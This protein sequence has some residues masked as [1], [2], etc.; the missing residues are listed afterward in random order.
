MI[1]ESKIGVNELELFEGSKGLF[2]TVEIESG[3]KVDLK[4]FL[5]SDKNTIAINSHRNRY[6]V[7]YKSDL[8]NNLTLIYME[9][10][11]DYPMFNPFK[12]KNA[13]MVYNKSDN[14]IYTCTYSY[15]QSCLEFNDLIVVDTS[16]FKKE[17]EQSINNRIIELVDNN[18]DNLNLSEQE[19]EKCNDII[20]KDN[21]DYKDYKRIALDS[22]L[23]SNHLNINSYACFE[24]DKRC[25]QKYEDGFKYFHLDFKGFN[26]I[27][28]I[29]N[30]ELFVNE[31]ANNIINEFKGIIYISIFR[32]N[33]IVE[34]ME[35]I[36]E[37]KKYEIAK[38]IIYLLKDTTR[39]TLNINQKSY[40]RI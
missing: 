7:F 30:K 20:L 4:R 19:I 35:E 26:L 10:Y 13:C 1:M 27:R 38:E 28:V 3:N 31:V 34:F 6:T 39:K 9:D 25:Y 16:H 15:G 18:L 24:F 32:N 22:Y 8:T 29:H 17:I 33:K 12:E 23:Y 36:K 40:I 14:K 5:E 2:D 21:E 11:S 37:S